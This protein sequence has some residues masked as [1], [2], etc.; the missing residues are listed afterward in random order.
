MGRSAGGP[1]GSGGSPATLD[2]RA[3]GGPV[4]ADSAVGEVPAVIRPHQDVVV[5]T[6]VV[7]AAIGDGEEITAGPGPIRPVQLDQH[8]AHVVPDAGRP[9][10]GGEIA[11]RAGDEGTN[12]VPTAVG[13][14]PLHPGNARGGAELD[15]PGQR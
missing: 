1:A 15:E 3:G 13:R 7:G 5:P 2:P 11:A 9:C 4:G 14:L 6:P 10:A 8:V 12:R